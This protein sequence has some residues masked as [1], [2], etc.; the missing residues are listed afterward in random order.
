[1]PGDNQ[2]KIGLKNQLFTTNGS[3]AIAFEGYF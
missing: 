2:A 3:H 1:M